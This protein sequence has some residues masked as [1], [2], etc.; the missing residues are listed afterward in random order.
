MK[1]IGMIVVDSIFESSDQR[2]SNFPPLIIRIKSLCETELENCAFVVRWIGV[3]SV[4]MKKRERESS[5][6]AIVHERTE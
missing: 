2:Q 1:L 4:R 3:F 5:L 6:N